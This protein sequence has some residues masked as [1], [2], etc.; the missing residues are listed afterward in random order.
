MLTAEVQRATTQLNSRCVCIHYSYVFD[1]IVAN[2]I[3]LP[4]EDL[5]YTGDGTIN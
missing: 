3:K 5:V 2:I 4:S 1:A